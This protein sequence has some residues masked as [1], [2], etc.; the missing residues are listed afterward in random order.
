MRRYPAGIVPHGRYHLVKGDVPMMWLVSHDRSVTFDLLGGKAICDRTA[1]E[2]V[3]IQ[4]DG[5]SGLIPPWRT[6][7]QKGASQDGITHVDSLY[8][9]AEVTLDVLAKGRDPERLRKV[10][11]D[12]IGS[13]D[14][15][16]TAELH[17]WTHQAGHWWAPLRWFKPPPGVN[18][19]AARRSH[20]MKLVLRADNAFWRTDPDVDL[21]GFSYDALSDPFSY[22][23]GSAVATTLGAN[24]PLRYTGT[25]GYVKADGSKVVWI[26]DLAGLTKTREVVIGPYK[27]FA[28]TTDN[29]VITV[30]TGSAFEPALPE[31]AYND[32]W[33]RMG[34]NPDGTWNGTGVRM[35]V[36]W[37]YVELA[38]FRN[39]TKTIMFTRPLL[40]G[41]SL[42][43]ETWQLV[44]GKPGDS[45]MFAGYRNGLELFSHK[46]PGTASDI[47][48]DYRGVGFGMQASAGLVSQATPSSVKKV[49]A[50]D[51]AEVTQEGF[52]RRSNCGDQKMHDT[53]TCFGPGVF[54]FWLGPDA[55]PNEFV[56]FGPLLE[57]QVVQID[58]DPRNRSVHD[59]TSKP[60]TPQ[61]LT[62]WEKALAGFLDF[63]GGSDAP[64]VEAIK[65]QWGITPP[66]GNLYSLLKGRWSDRS[67]IPP[68]T[69]GAPVKPHTVKVS[70]TGGNAASRIIASGVPQRRY[71]L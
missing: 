55:G 24:W 34:R 11:G 17:W 52:L 47:G 27:G 63:V 46:E 4:K 1:P 48:A 67:A 22:V 68:K 19:P 15:I 35:R 20:R 13:I 10:M 58:S 43:G 16:R 39:F 30:Q 40:I 69:V 5:I 37:G 7:D 49:T 54:R 2:S 31:S 36:G 56:E 60:P 71:P 28:T 66:Q 8:D 38:R 45:R 57:N 21:W 41:P 70:I 6:I 32:I 33:G 44:C 42:A 9:P 29:Q 26:D 64:L 61:A 12:L 23:S 59:L 53:Y 14:A 65:S 25:G 51:N 62:D 18:S 50:G 3:Q